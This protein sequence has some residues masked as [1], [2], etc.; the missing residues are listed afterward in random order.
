MRQIWTATATVAA[1]TTATFGDVIGNPYDGVETSVTLTQD[2]VFPAAAHLSTWAVSDFQT[3]EDYLLYDVVVQGRA[4]GSSDGSGANFDIYDGL[5]WDGGAIVHSAINGY[6]TLHA[7]GAFGA[8][9][10]GAFLAAG[11]Y[12]IV[13][14][15]EHDFL[16]VGGNTL[17]YNTTTGDNN[18]YAWNPGLGQG[19]P[20]EFTAVVDGAG[21]PI[22]VNWQLT[23]GEVPAPS[24][25]A[26][27]AVGGLFA[28]R[29]RV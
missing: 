18:D 20:D 13:F 15:V 6:D 24:C 10:D 29:R 14:Q 16:M 27:L 2:F 21:A 19:W 12:Y 22:D 1:L 11:S 9:F 28:R 25:V 7:Q 5:P 26:L 17:T 3:T 8:D 23:V 4:T